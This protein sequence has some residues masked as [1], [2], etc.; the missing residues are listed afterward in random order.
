MRKIKISHFIGRQL[1][2]LRAGQSYYS[3]GMQTITALGIVFLVFTN[4][5]TLFFILLFPIAIFGA[6]GIGYL[7]DKTNVTTMDHRKTI[8]MTHRYLTTADFKNNEFT[9]ILIESIV[10]CF[11]ALQENKSID[12]DIVEKKYKKFLKKWNPPKK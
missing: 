4:L 2:R 11:K 7:M 5:N 10:E 9:K 12:P 8:E 6:F 3:M 1:S